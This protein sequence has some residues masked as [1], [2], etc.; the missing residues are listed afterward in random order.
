ML[1]AKKT[2]LQHYCHCMPMG[3]SFLSSW[4]RQEGCSG[5]WLHG[6]ATRVAPKADGI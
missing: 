4:G 5:C 1:G 3:L 2:S 6:T